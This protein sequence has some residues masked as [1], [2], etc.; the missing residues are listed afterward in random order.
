MYLYVQR[1]V[2]ILNEKIKNVYYRKEKR[3]KKDNN[4]GHQMMCDIK[5]NVFLYQNSSLLSL[6]WK[7][8][9]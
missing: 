3:K 7:T 5:T 8:K 9:K 2:Y 6:I 4:K 1:Y